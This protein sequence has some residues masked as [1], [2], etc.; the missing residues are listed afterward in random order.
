MHTAAERE[1][2]AVPPPSE[3]GEQHLREFQDNERSIPTILTTSQKLSTGVDARNVCKAPHGFRDH[4]DVRHHAAGIVL[5]ERTIKRQFMSNHHPIWRI[6]HSTASHQC[7]SRLKLSA[8]FS[9]ADIGARAAK[10]RKVPHSI[11]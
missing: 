11:P 7:K 4:H 8:Q 10:G 1:V 6:C 3:L 2:D 9:L 5:Q